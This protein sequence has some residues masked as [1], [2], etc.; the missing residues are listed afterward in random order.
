ML[1]HLIKEN[2]LWPSFQECGLEEKDL[3]FIKEMIAGFTGS[4]EKVERSFFC[5]ILKYFLVQM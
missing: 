2:D 4:P 5:N 3:I 1:D